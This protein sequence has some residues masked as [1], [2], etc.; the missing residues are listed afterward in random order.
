MSQT[1]QGASDRPHRERVEHIHQ[2]MAAHELME[3]VWSLITPLSGMD[4]VKRSISRVMI[5][6]RK[7]AYLQLDAAADASIEAMWTGR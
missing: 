2:A 7:S 1:K 4:V 5:E 6:L 3:R